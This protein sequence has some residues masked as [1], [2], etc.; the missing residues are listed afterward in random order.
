MS[1][2]PPPML[3]FPGSKD[4]DMYDQSAYWGRAFKFFNLVD[5]RTLAPGALLGMPLARAQARLKA[6]EDNEKLVKHSDEQDQELWLA[7]KV[8]T[9]TIH[10]DTGQEIPAPFRM[11]GFAPF[12]TPIVVGMLLANSP[13]QN[14]FWQFANQSH[15]ALIN[16][17][18]GNKSGGEREGEMEQAL[19]SF[20]LATSSA[21]GVCLGADKLVSIL[22]APTLGRFVPF[23]AVASANLINI[24]AMRRHELQDGVAVLDAQGNKLGSSVSAAKKAL[25][26]TAVS[27]V[28]LPVP[29]LVFSPLILMGLER[30]APKALQNPPVRIAAQASIGFTMFA[31]GLPLSLALFKHTGE[32]ARGDLEPELA[33]KL[34]PGQNIAF[35]NKGL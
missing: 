11:S 6:W 25:S 22:K 27:R 24:G 34:P 29:I 3:R 19:A 14:V 21:V 18:N 13:A 4:G 2:F 5:P 15:N 10:P 1:D 17:Y 33:E 28:V 26:E 23:F 8:V 20:A 7:R 16:H 30:L 9:S 31:I 12:G 35:Y 32:V